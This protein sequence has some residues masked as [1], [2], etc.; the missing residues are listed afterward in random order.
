MKIIYWTVT[1]RAVI[2]RK[3]KRSARPLRWFRNAELRDRFLY[4]LMEFYR[5]HRDAIFLMSARTEDY[6]NLCDDIY[7]KPLKAWR[8]RVVFAQI[9]IPG[10]FGQWAFED[11]IRLF[12]CKW[13]R[14]LNPHGASSLKVI[15]DAGK[16]AEDLRWT[17]F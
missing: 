7:L 11:I 12:A 13:L 4:L 6:E 16:I 1:H 9:K 10:L 5:E 2:Y 8:E 17:G 15:K 3:K 14:I